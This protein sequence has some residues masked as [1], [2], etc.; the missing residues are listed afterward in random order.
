MERS[1]YRVKGNGEGPGIMLGCG[2]RTAVGLGCGDSEEVSLVV[3]E[4]SSTANALL[5]KNISKRF[6]VN[7]VLSY[8]KR[9]TCNNDQSFVVYSSRIK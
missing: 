7:W 4:R 6:L 8:R 1:P 5:N 3:Q 9:F 2:I